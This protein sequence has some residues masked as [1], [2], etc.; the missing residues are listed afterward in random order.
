ME[1]LK[2]HEHAQH[3][4]K[5]LEAARNCLEQF[6]EKLKRLQTAEDRWEQARSAP[7]VFKRVRAVSRAARNRPGNAWEIPEGARACLAPPGNARHCPTLP[8]AV[9]GSPEP[10]SYTHLRAHETSAHL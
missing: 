8:R 6:R 3:R 2:V 5:A 10:V 7:I 4:W 9:P 1:S